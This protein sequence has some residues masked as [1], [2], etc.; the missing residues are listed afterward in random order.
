[1]FTKKQPNVET[2]I[3]EGSTFVGELKSTGTLRVNGILEGGASVDWVIVGEGGII[4][5][6]VVCRGSIVGGKVEGDIH[7]DD[8][9][10]IRPR[11]ELMGDVYAQ[12]LAMSEGAFFEGRSHMR[13][14]GAV[15]HGNIAQ[16][17]GPWRLD[18]T[19]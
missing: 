13:Q 17:A 8:L 16:L 7:S 6:N 10:E 14:P 3:G 4:R 5:G 2:I 1:V 19:H 11:G 15:D 9:V 18:P 12:R